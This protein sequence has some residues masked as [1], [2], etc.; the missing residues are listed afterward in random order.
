MNKIF[1]Y[2]IYIVGPLETPNTRPDVFKIEMPKGA[3]IISVG[4]DPASGCPAIWAIV[5]P[6]APM[7]WR[8]F[9]VA[10]TGHDLR[11]D[12]IHG[13]FL[14]TAFCGALVWH[15]FEVMR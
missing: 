5:D 4:M 9:R 13:R 15:I 3:G 11:D 6:D 7:E 10:G 12:H 14:G 1:K 8:N 2:P